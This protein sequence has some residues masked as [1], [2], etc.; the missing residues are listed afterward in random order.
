MALKAVKISDFSL[1][2]GEN[3]II[4]LKGDHKKTPT[5]EW[6]SYSYTY[7]LFAC[8]L[9]AIDEYLTA[10]IQ[11]SF[12]PVCPVVEMQFSGCRIFGQGRRS[13]LVVRSPFISPGF[14]YFSLRMCH[15]ATYLS[16]SK[17]FNASHLGSVLSSSLFVSFG[18]NSSNRFSASDLRVPSFTP[19]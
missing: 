1:I 10:I 19:G 7:C 6:E 9:I 3:V 14:R 2:T 16:V 15:R 4:L 12:V 5:L 18:C 13:G 8:F 17:S 11:F